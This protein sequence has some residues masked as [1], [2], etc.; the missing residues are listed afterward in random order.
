MPGN[1]DF[2]GGSDG[3]PFIVKN[4]IEL[5]NAVRVQVEANL[6]ENTWG[7]FSQTGFSIVLS[8]KNQHTPSGTNI[9]PVC[10]VTDVTIRYVHASHAGGGILMANALSGDGTNGAAALAGERY[11]IHDVVLDDISDNYKGGGSLF[12]IMNTWPTNPLN[13]ITINHVTG[14]PDAYSHVLEL[15]NIYYTTAPM[16]GLVFTNNMVGTGRYPVWNTG[17][18]TSCAF[19]DVPITSINLCFTTHTFANN[20]LLATPAAFPPSV[21]PTGNLFPQTTNDAGFVD[22][23]NGNGGNYALQSSSVYKGMGTDGKDLG[24]DIVGLNAALANVE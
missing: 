3:N 15:G 6:M 21:W 23:N 14:F 7:G 8:P 19:Y 1:A 10:Q 12:M 11:S 13:T 24:A 5:K 17:G 16:Y 18:T 9:C 22:Y 4:H 20:A 2:V